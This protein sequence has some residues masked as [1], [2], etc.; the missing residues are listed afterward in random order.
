ML[1]RKITE[2][3]FFSQETFPEASRLA[4]SPPPPARSSTHFVANTPLKTALT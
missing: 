3:R 1:H 2:T 4:I